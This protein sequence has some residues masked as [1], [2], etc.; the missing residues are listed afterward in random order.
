M[1]SYENPAPTRQLIYISSRISLNLSPIQVS[2]STAHPAKFSEAVARALGSS[3]TFNFHR[4]ILPKEFQGLL[5]KEQR[6]IDVPLADVDLVKSVIE[7]KVDQV[8]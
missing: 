3:P 1:Y 8:G 2:L 4:D 7:S 6:V 5:E